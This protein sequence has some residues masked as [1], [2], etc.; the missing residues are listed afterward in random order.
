MDPIIIPNLVGLIVTIILQILTSSGCIKPTDYVPQKP[1][2]QITPIPYVTPVPNAT[3][4]PNNP[5]T[6]LQIASPLDKTSFISTDTI[7]CHA[8]ISNGV[9]YPDAKVKWMIRGYQFNH[10]TYP[11]PSPYEGINRFEL[12]NAYFSFIPNPPPAP[13]GRGIGPNYL[14]HLYYQII[15]L[16]VNTSGTNITDIHTL[17]QDEKDQCRQEYIDIRRWNPETGQ[18]DS[19]T[20]TPERGEFSSTICTVHFTHEGLRGNSYYENIIATDALCTGL[21]AVRTT[22]GKQMDLSAGYR[23]PAYNETL[24][25]SGLNS[26]H[27]FGK[28]VDVRINRIF[29]NSTTFDPIQQW[30]Y[31]RNVAHAKNAC[32]EPANYRRSVPD[33][34][35]IHMQWDGA[36]DPGW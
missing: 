4:A 20:R 31:M 36:C 29:D 15:A 32:V 24:T 34:S 5:D 13:S 12:P 28:A 8:T 17:E 11:S 6:N 2:V 27:I 23:N 22:V 30:N 10:L 18:Y 33:Y 3:P 35:Y 9:Y 25:G 19:I 26:R 7:M 14:E 21:E 1:S 16:V